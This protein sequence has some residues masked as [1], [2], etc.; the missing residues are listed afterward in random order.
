ME[1]ESSTSPSPPLPLPFSESLFFPSSPP[2]FFLLWLSLHALLLF[3]SPEV[4][5][6]LPRLLCVCPR[7]PGACWSREIASAPFERDERR[8]TFF[9]RFLFLL[10]SLLLSSHRR[11]PAKLPPDPLQGP[12][13]PLRDS[14][15]QL[16]DQLP[17]LVGLGLLEREQHE[18][19]CRSGRGLGASCSPPAA[20]RQPRRRRREAALPPRDRGQIRRRGSVGRTEL[21][22]RDPTPDLPHQ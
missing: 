20:E 12:L 2:C 1:E 9:F 4:C 21:Y 3:S 18:V 10:Y 5:R 16:R 11:R 13:Y 15:I 7:P 6:S 8:S 22:R 19:V 14:R 17:S